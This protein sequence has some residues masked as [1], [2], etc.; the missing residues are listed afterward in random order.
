MCTTKICEIDW[1]AEG[2]I[3]NAQS[4][5]DE[6]DFSII[7]RIF[8]QE[9][10]SV[11]SEIDECGKA[12]F[13]NEKWHWV[14]DWYKKSNPQKAQSASS[15]AKYLPEIYLKIMELLAGKM[16]V[17]NIY[18]WLCGPRELIVCLHDIP[19]E[20]KDVIHPTELMLELR[21]FI[22]EKIKTL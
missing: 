19:G 16:A 9:E 21:E 5:G 15:E 18:Y 6:K 17:I 20:A 22:H 2:C 8:P 4:N 10:I 13:C 1:N 11:N 12:F 14:Y 7:I 3:T